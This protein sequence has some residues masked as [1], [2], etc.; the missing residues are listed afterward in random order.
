M[1][2][3]D[4]EVLGYPKKYIDR[5]DLVKIMSGSKKEVKRSTSVSIN[6]VCR[7]QN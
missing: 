5:E 3:H 4:K 2:S 1:R 7:K 6:D